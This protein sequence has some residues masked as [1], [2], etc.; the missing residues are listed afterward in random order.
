MTRL[1]LNDNEDLGLATDFYELTMALAY[2][3]CE[4]KDVIGIFEMFVRKFP[5]HRNYLIIAGLEQII[6]YLVNLKFSPDQID[7]LKK[8]DQFKN[9]QK[10][11][12][13]LRNIRFTGN[14]WAVPEG[15]VI[16]PN[17]PILRIEAPIIQSQIVETYIL[18]MMNFQTLIASKASR[19][20]NAAGNKSVVEFGF[21]RAHS[22]SAALYASRASYIAGCKSTSNT[23]ASFHFGIP[24]S[25]TMAHSFVLSF[26]DEIE[27]FRKFV[28]IFPNGFLLI[29]T[30]DSLKAIKNVIKNEIKCSGVR[31]DSGNL[32][33]ICKRIRKI[34]DRNG[35]NETKIMVSG[36][37]N[38]YIIKKLLDKKIP[39]DHFGIGTELVTSRDDPALNGVYKLV[40]IKKQGIVK[41][42]YEMI[43]KMKKS[44]NKISFPGPKQIYR[45]IQH[46]EIKK[47]IIAL[48]HE[49]I[50]MGEPLLRQFIKEGLP[51]IKN[52][53]NLK[54][55][56]E[57]YQQQMRILPIQF[58]DLGDTVNKFPVYIS[59]E[60][61][62]IT[63][64]L[65]GNF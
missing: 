34:L 38:E 55:I 39:I 20:V 61:Q 17:E 49:Q 43:Y 45:I 47:D 42:K 62:K 6:S 23:L 59:N 26:D 53:P 65:Q 31:I 13:Y 7:F 12:N 48:G 32:F 14:L 64:S 37:I 58:K 27:A 11:L 35:Y 21:R 19:I 41:D 15:T 29:D 10:F 28:S 24:M 50:K 3:K 60:L 54:E 63:R 16:F 51:T 30:Y 33:S 57:Y 5:R 46:K 44:V 52:L 56:N 36:D 1:P 22:P 25:G 8:Y 18:S 9:N 40:A 4:M 2:F